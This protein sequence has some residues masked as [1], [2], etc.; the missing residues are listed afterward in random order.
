[1]QKRR[2]TRNTVKARAR[3][4]IR[5]ALKAP[6]QKQQGAV[7]VQVEWPQEYVKHGLPISDL[8]RLSLSA[9]VRGSRT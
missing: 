1:M 6:L 2:L 5:A 8:V 9:H 7:R 4:F 3:E